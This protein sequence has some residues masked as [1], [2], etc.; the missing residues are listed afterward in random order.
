M[1][2]SGS[3]SVFCFHRKYPVGQ[4]PVQVHTSSQTKHSTPDPEMVQVSLLTEGTCV[5]IDRE[6]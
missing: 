1:R 5:G 4:Q 2:A 6:K 3:M